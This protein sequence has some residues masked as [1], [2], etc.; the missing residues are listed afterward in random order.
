MG[1]ASKLI[2]WV[3]GLQ[4]REMEEAWDQFLDEYAAV[5][6][7]VVHLFEREQD[8]V[9]DCFLFVCEQ[10]K[11]DRLR[12]LRRFE[13]DGAASFP[14]WLRAV[15]RNLCLDWRRKRF[16]RPR[17]FRSIAS[18]PEV[19]QEVFRCI[20]F[21]KLS[22]NETLHTV[23]ATH[24]A[25]DR[26]GLADSLTRIRE[27]LSPRQSWLLV[28]RNPYLESLSAEGSSGSGA[29]RERELTD[30][31]EDPESEAAKQEFLDALH[32][33]MAG[34]SPRERLLLRLRFEQ[35]L[36]LEEIANLMQLGTPLKAQRSI[37]K[38]LSKVRQVLLVKGISSV[39]VKDR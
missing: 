19:D 38:A 32:E 23:R 7:Q 6:L 29:N 25:L 13:A 39:S 11:R 35:D 17:I 10:L 21:R 24:P 16:G 1:V 8:R 31:H 2:E 18:L 26:E 22:E 36:S 37:Q 27:S 28:S 34:I 33:A 4:A 15:V 20:Y 3:P 30:P 5:I 12:R 9:D 14:T